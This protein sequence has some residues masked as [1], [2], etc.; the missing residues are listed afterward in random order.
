MAKKSVT[1]SISLPEELS[2]KIDTMVEDTNISRSAVITAMLSL[3]IKYG[4]V[5]GDILKTK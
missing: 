2:E 1:I 3:F 5:I 4:D